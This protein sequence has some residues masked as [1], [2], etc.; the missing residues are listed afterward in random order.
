MLN[1]LIHLYHRLARAPIGKCHLCGK[2]I[3]GP[4]IGWHYEHCAIW[5][6]QRYGKIKRD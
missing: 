2:R 3:Y 5:L 4:S 1:A 6:K